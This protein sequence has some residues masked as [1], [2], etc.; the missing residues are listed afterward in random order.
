[1][2]WPE[3]TPSNPPLPCFAQEFNAAD[4]K[5]AD[6]AHTVEC[7][8]YM[9]TRLNRVPLSKATF[10]IL[11]VAYELRFNIEADDPETPELQ[12]VYILCHTTVFGKEPTD[13]SM[14]RHREAI[15]TNVR[16]ADCS[17]RLFLLA[18]MLGHQRMEKEFAA[19]TALAK[20]KPF[21]LHMLSEHKALERARMYAELCRKEFGTFTLSTLSVLSETN[22]DA[23]DIE[24]RLL[25]SE[26]TVGRWL[27]GHKM[28]H[29]GP[30]YDLLYECEEINLDPYW[31]AI[32]DNY[33]KLVLDK[34]VKSSQE[35]RRHRYSVVQSVSYLK[36][37][38]N[39]AIAV[40]RARQQMMPQA[41]TRV[42]DYFGYQVDDFEI[43]DKPV[44]NPLEL[45]VLLGR[46]IQHFNLLNYL[47]GEKSIFNR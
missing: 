28:I 40:F 47:S 32:D 16:K 20:S 46:A 19:K 6:C 2:K 29:G 42:L 14:G 39:I 10:H 22:N 26:I 5:C 24:Q 15:L 34:E 43:E 45:W 33:K 13:Y 30:P 41:I 4:P 35:L 3:L 11:P 44:T 7:Q 8:R 9:R 12:R 1:M 27:V 17:L 37:H 38:R 23:N 21:K 36:R 18:N 25:N 31:L